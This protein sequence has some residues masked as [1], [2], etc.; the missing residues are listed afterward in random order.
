M[1]GGSLCSGSGGLDL[2]LERSLGVEWAWHAEV[3]AA[4]SKILE[5]RWPGVPN[6]GDFTTIEWEDVERVELFA[7]GFPCFVAG[8]LILTRDGYRPIETLVVGDL[9]LT[10]EGRWRPVSFC[11][12]TPDAPVRRI[13][14]PGVNLVCTDEHPFYARRGR[15]DEQGR[16]LGLDAPEWRDA[17]DLVPEDFLGQ[18]LPPVEA[19]ESRPLAF[20][21]LI[22]RY[23]ADGWIVDRRGRRNGRVVICCANDELDDLCSLVADAGYRAAVERGK[24]ASKLHVTRG[25]LYDFVRSF[26]RLAHG[27]MLP[28]FVHSLGPEESEAILAGYLDGDGY[29]DERGRCCRA[30]T[31]SEQLAYGLALL[32]QRARGVVA[33]VHPYERAGETEIE[34]RTVQQRPEWQ[35]RIPFSNRSCFVEDGYGWKKVKRNER[36]PDRVTVYNIAVEEDESYVANGAI[37]HNCPA[38]D[39][40]ASAGARAL[41]AL[42]PAVV[43]L[44]NVD[45]IRTSRRGPDLP[46][47]VRRLPAYFARCGNRQTGVSFRPNRSRSCSATSSRR[48]TATGRR[49]R[50]GSAPAEPRRRPT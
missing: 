3:D 22:G 20:W 32:A 13:C 4:A 6:L 49:R 14:A 46:S 27:K 29:L 37:V 19:V 42:R 25:D 1:K 16:R 21:R 2:G 34:G 38:V 47:Y 10:H 39:A 45:G 5:V 50:V 35:V 44:E 48:G 43:V 17:A 28:G 12:E 8:T 9:V 33:S 24:S 36:L 11:H 26:G 23:L 15:Y 40:C 41:R 7:A 18:T 31:V 30:T